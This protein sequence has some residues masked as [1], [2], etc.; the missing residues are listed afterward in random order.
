MYRSAHRQRPS[1]D[2]KEVAQSLL[3]IALNIGQSS[4]RAYLF[5]RKKDGIEFKFAQFGDLDEARELGALSLQE[6]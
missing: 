3:G 4:G 1:A 5:F 6:I 2:D